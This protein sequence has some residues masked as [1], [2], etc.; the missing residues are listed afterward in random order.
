M[1]YIFQSKQPDTQKDRSS[2]RHLF[3]G[4]KCN[5]VAVFEKTHLMHQEGHDSC[6]D[7]GVSEVL[8]PSHPCLLK[9]VETVEKREN[10]LDLSRSWKALRRW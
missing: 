2:I 4:K 6:S 10:A 3:A 7:D 9:D 5:M 1:V 8:V